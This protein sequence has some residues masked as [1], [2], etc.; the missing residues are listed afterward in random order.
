MPDTRAGR[1]GTQGA[2]HARGVGGRPSSGARDGLGG[3]DNNEVYRRWVAGIPPPPGGSEGIL[4]NVSADPGGSVAP[5]GPPVRRRHLDAYASPFVKSQ[6]SPV[7]SAHA[8]RPRCRAAPSA[9]WL[10]LRDHPPELD[11]ADRELG[12]SESAV[13]PARREGHSDTFVALP[14][15]LPSHLRTVTGEAPRDLVRARWC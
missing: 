6:S 15:E 1:R 8:Y 7:S 4:V 9:V 13:L 3:A 14:E 2:P 11:R 10:N 5:S 12:T